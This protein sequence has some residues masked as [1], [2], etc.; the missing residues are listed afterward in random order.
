MKKCECSTHIEVL[1][2]SSI[3]MFFFCFF[4]LSCNVWRSQGH[5]GIHSV[6][7]SEGA[8]LQPPSIIQTDKMIVCPSGAS[9]RSSCTT[10]ILFGTLILHSSV[11]MH[12][13]IC[14]TSLP[15]VLYLAPDRAPLNI[16]WTMIGA[17]LTLHWDPV[18]AVETESKVT[19][20]LV[21]P[22]SLQSPDL[23]PQ[24]RVTVFALAHFS[25]SPFS[26]LR[27]CLRDTATTTSALS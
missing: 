22:S 10:V 2:I 11:Y 16:Q 18:V 3:C 15:M 7:I 5:L 25:G 27:C 17:T 21:G 23:S 8:P 6:F 12:H 9:V 13:V 19:G 24:S 1:L 4:F 20:Y 26:R 14:R